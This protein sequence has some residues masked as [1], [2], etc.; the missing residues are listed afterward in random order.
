[1]LISAM[2][3]SAQTIV[4]GDMDGDGIVTIGDVTRVVATITGNRATEIIDI[5]ALRE[6]PSALAGI[7]HSYREDGSEAPIQMYLKPYGSWIKPMLTNYSFTYVPGIGENK[8]LFVIF[9]ADTREV[10]TV[11]EI[12]ELT[13]EKMVMRA[14]GSNKSTT[15]YRTAPITDLSIAPQQITGDPGETC[16]LT[17]TL[18]PSTDVTNQYISWGSDNPNVATVSNTGLV[19]MVSGGTAY[20]TCRSTDGSYLSCNCVV[21]VRQQVESI[22]LDRTSLVLHKDHTYSLTATVS[23]ENADNKAVTWSSSDTNVATV[24]DDGIVTGKGSGTATITCTAQDGSVAAASCIVTVPTPEYVDL[25]LP[26]RT[27][28]ATFNVG[29]STPNEVGEEFR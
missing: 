6:D 1:M 22:T 20:I 7:W 4:K 16:Q 21:K 29:A 11:N 9:D 19:T 2:G 10:L 15:M 24:S 5:D 14:P 17:L 8:G 27:L 13:K 28:W 23:P 26:S 25:G 18:T 12:I 3:V